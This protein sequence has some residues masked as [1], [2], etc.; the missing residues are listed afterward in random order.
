M[1]EEIGPISGNPA[2][3]EQPHDRLNMA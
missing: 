1:S 3:I 2:G